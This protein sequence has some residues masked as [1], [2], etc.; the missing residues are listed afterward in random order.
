MPTIPE[1]GRGHALRVSRPASYLAAVLATLATAF[2]RHALDP[3]WG[4]KFPFTMFYPAVALGAWLGGIGPGL[5]AT[6]L[7]TGFTLWLHPPFGSSLR[8]SAPDLIAVSLFVLV[9]VL[10][11]VLSEALHRA[12]RRVEVTRDTLRDSEARLRGIVTS[13]PDA[14]ITI[15]SMQRIMLFSAG[16]ETIFGHAAGAMIGHPVDRLMPKRLRERHRR[17]VDAFGS[18]DVS[19]RAM[20]GELP[21]IGLRRDGTEF[22]MEARISQIAVGAQKFYTVILRDI[23][24]RQ[25]AEVERERLLASEHAARERAEA[26]DQAK[27]EFLAML[28]H[29][30]R[31]PLSAVRNAVATASLDETRRPRALEI[32]R[33]QV[34][35][36]GRLIDDLLDSARITQGRVLVH[37]E[38]ANLTE[39]IERA[40]ESVRAL[41]EGRGVQLVV[42]HT[43]FPIRVEADPARLEQVFVNLLSNGAKYTDAGG[44]IE[45]TSEREGDEVAIHV[46]D[47]GIGIAPE[48]LPRIWELFAQGDRAL[49]RAQGGLG[50]GLTLARRL[51]ELHGGRIEAHSEGLGKGAEFVVRLPA[52]PV[53]AADSL[54][55]AASPPPPQRSARV[56]VVEDNPDTAESLMMFLEVLGHRVRAVYDGMAALD[57]A[58]TSPP[59]VM[60]VDIGLPGMDG[61]EVA[62]RVRRDPD[63]DRVILVALTGYG[64]EADKRQAMAAGF[65]HH[66][67]KP[68]SPEALHGLVARLGGPEAAKPTVH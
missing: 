68:V 26:A 22:P 67:V 13:T 37:K 50:I 17:H 36:L 46:R 19:M 2:V 33:R 21:L 34:D 64:R 5:F 52:L 58:R 62:R 65:D 18:T 40:V 51:V 48:M 32:A 1:E 42:T 4:S 60:L 41:V 25:R 16:A 47:T 57:A 44:R 14:I 23:T 54:P 49:D 66:L 15:D 3:I 28:G 59:D 7:V 43:P 61:Y 20:G 30:L 45:V 8:A 6:A 53:T 38:R 55:S 39:I 24:E 9:N 12:R 56:L 11:S 27:D 35:Q 10:L 63:L 29:E 31:N